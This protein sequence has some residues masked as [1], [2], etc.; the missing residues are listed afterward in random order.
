M[1]K[2]NLRIVEPVQERACLDKDFRFAKL[3]TC[4]YPGKNTNSKTKNRVG[5]RHL[6]ICLNKQIKKIKK[7]IARMLEL[8]TNKNSCSFFLMKN[9]YFGSIIC[10]CSIETSG[11]PDQPRG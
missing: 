7:I 2:C 1:P 6:F 3:L 8:P 10:I 5:S 9:L 11:I 4:I